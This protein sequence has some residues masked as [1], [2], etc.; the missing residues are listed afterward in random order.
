MSNVYLDN[1]R[2]MKMKDVDKKLKKI[3]TWRDNDK[4]VS[5]TVVLLL[6]VAGFV[7]INKG[8]A[9]KEQA[10]QQFKSELQRDLAANPTNRDSVYNAYIDRLLSKQR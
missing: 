1:N 8:L 5:L 7:V 4:V 10:K 9:A 2:I 3:G 6:S